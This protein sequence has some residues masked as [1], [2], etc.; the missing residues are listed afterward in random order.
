MHSAATASA[1]V[2]GASMGTG[3]P[4]QDEG[5]RAESQ[6]LKGCMSHGCTGSWCGF[7]LCLWLMGSLPVGVQAPCFQSFEMLA[8]VYSVG[9]LTPPCPSVGTQAVFL[10]GGG[11]EYRLNRLLLSNM[12]KCF[13]PLPNI[14]KHSLT[15][16]FSLLAS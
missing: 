8:Q 14:F 2:G 10:G 11:S 13:I 5:V 12:S 1:S 4:L 7:T 15:C 3:E 6:K 9:Q 16:F